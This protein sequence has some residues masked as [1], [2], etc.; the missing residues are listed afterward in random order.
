MPQ[1]NM[2]VDGNKR[3]IQSSEIVD[4]VVNTTINGSTYTAIALPAGAS[5]KSLI[6]RARSGQPWY[7]ATSSNPSTYF[8]CLGSLAINLVANAGE[9]IF[10]ALGSGADTL[11][12]LFTN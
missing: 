10:Y 4:S 5:C 6:A 12:V 7:L 1:I 3:V 2:P 11:E 8:T 9:T